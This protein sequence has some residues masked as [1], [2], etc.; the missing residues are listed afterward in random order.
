MG[1][2]LRDQLKN[3]ERGAQRQGAQSGGSGTDLTTT[4]DEINQ[5]HDA[6]INLISNMGF[7]LANTQFRLKLG[8]FS[9]TNDDG[10]IDTT[11]VAHSPATDTSKIRS[12]HIKNTDPVS[13]ISIVTDV[14]N[15]SSNLSLDMGEEISWNLG[16]FNMIGAFSLGNMTLSTSGNYRMSW[17]EEF[18][19]NV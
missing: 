15:V 2:N 16:G 6:V 9:G 4:N 8:A 18:D 7:F 19:P 13:K 17:V 12:L 1:D 5:V 10:R 11:I 14:A 3:I